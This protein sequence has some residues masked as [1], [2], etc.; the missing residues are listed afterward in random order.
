MNLDRLHEIIQSASAQAR[1]GEVVVEETPTAGIAVTHAYFMPHVDEVKPEFERVDLHF[2]WVVVDKQKAEAAKGELIEI[3][4][5]YPQPERLAG[6]PSYIEV[7]GVI[8]D[9]G[10][11]LQLFGLGAVLKL[12]EVIT[13]KTLGFTGAEAD[14][15]AGMG[16]VMISGF[17]PVAASANTQGG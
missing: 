17:Q 15:M 7:G 2:V 3:L 1:K 9:Q 11:A 14:Q 12:W 16:F 10:A 13:P 8:G 5:T 6:G 4:K